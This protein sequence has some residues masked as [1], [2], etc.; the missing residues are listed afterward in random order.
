[1]PLLD[2]HVAAREQ[3]FAVERARTGRARDQRVV[4]DGDELARDRAGLRARVK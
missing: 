1:M 3:A 4:D 2:D